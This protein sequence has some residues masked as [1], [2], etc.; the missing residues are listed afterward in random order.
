MPALDDVRVLD[1]TRLLPGGYCTMLLADL[2]A[3]VIKVESAAAPDWM[4]WIPPLVGEYS[5]VFHAINRNKR[6]ISLNLKSD[7]GRDAFLTIAGNA[8][9]VVESFRPGVMD[10][11]GIGFDA[12]RGRNSRLVL[13]SI[14]G[15]GQD[16]P[17]RDR[18]GHDL[19]YMAVSG[20][21]SL[22]GCEGGD[23]VIPAVQAADLAAG[24]LNAVVAILAALHQRARTGEG[25]H[26]DVAMLDGVLSL[27]AMQAA[28][29]FAGAGASA[30]GTFMLNGAFPC[31]RIYRCADGYLSLAA[32]EPRFWNNF[33][34]A[35]ALPQLRDS[36]LATGDD[37][38]RV[39]DA[40]QKRLGDE[41]VAH[42]TDVLEGLD[43]CCEPILGIDSAL[44][45]PQVRHRELRIPAG[46][47]G[48]I[49]QIATP[50][51]LSTSPMQVRRRAPGYGEHTEEILAEAGYDAEAIRSLRA[52]G[53]TE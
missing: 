8:D 26:C 42:W 9:V 41:T 30:A 2:G 37:A 34:D 45:S 10:R 40:V 43:V 16:G 23:P 38:R 46:V 4:R 6:S 47:A 22:T 53:V 7:A 48:P 20:A 21:L 1:L 3:D 39:I 51:R 35:V 5:A 18:A 44:D 49:D 52:A 11:L 50:I 36:G 13:C 19:N 27:L 17:Y 31:Y 15:Y 24:S 14:S 12:L 29:Y 32:L 25:Q 33:V 28:T